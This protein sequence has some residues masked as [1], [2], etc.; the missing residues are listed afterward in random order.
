I[1]TL[2]RRKKRTATPRPSPPRRS[3]ASK[4][5]FTLLRRRPLVEVQASHKGRP[6]R[7]DT[8]RHEWQPVCGG[9]SKCPGVCLCFM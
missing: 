8:T 6:T 9:G 5:R 2:K 4:L 1:G 7:H 3:P